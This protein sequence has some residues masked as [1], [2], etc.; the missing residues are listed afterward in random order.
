M[1]LAARLVAA[2]C[3]AVLAIAAVAVDDTSATELAERISSGRRSQSYYE[4]AMLAQDAIVGGLEAQRKTSLKAI[5]QANRT[6]ARSKRAWW[7]TTALVA[8][9]KARLAGLEA[10]YVGVPVEQI[11]TGFPARLELV[12]REV[13]RLKS[14]RQEL[15]QAWRS[16]I[17]VRGYRQDRLASLRA[18]L[19]AAIAR[20]EAAE[21]GLGAYI[22]EVTRLAAA[23]AEIQSDVR[24]SAVGTTFA[25]PSIGRIA[26]TYGCT[27]FR[28]L[29][30]RGSC[31]H[32]HDGLDIVSRYGSAVRAAAD[33]V[34]AFAGWNPW[35]E[36]GRAWIIVL[37]HP[38][39]YV[40]RY[41]HLIPT[42]IV[43]VGEFVRQGQR[44]GRMGN[45]G[46]SL[47]THLHFEL[48]DGGTAV[49]PWGYLP[50]G[51][52]KVKVADHK[53]KH[54]AKGRSG[55]QSGKGKGGNLRDGPAS[56]DRAGDPHPVTLPFSASSSEI[57]PTDCVRIG[58]ALDAGPGSCGVPDTPDSAA[59][60][61]MTT[62]DE[63]GVR[64]PYRGTSPLPE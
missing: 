9:R 23:R 13:T 56:A 44:I 40:T 63:P 46:M 55:R 62:S 12:R 43:R 64:M 4:S 49:S 14:R 60:A 47:G 21:G 37:S 20:R 38:D 48:L 51:M 22:I 29:P 31:P 61:S 32:F 36:S 28:L 59:G 30:P 35:D 2:G 54:G 10:R 57:S 33:G 34:V 7:Y 18:P 41:G 27:G 52:V 50:A 8:R 53:G 45:T 11:P 19:R 1:G 42:E 3:A 24:L 15:G 26:Q 17:R 58:G 39:G 6:I 16:A 5:R 25:W